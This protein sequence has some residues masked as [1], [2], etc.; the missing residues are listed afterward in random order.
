[1]VTGRL[2]KRSAFKDHQA[3]EEVWLRSHQDKTVI[4]SIASATLFET[5]LSDASV[6]AHQGA[7]SYAR[8]QIPTSYAYA[9][10]RWYSQ[11]I[12][13][14]CALI[15]LFLDQSTEEDHPLESPNH[16]QLS[17]NLRE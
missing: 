17:E 9:P 14:Y 1:M 15:R 7:H 13:G 6:H 10:G 5:K 2:L 3:E 16:F 11:T 8:S 4:N 12:I